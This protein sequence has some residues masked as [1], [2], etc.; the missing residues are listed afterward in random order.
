MIRFAYAY[1]YMYVVIY[2]L[3]VSYADM[4]SNTLLLRTFTL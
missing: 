2:T 1:Y 3:Y 4:L